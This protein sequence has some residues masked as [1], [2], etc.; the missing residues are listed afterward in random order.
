MVGDTCVEHVR[1]LIQASQAYFEDSFDSTLG[2]V[3]RPEFESALR[4]HHRGD[5][6]EDSVSWFA[7][8]KTVYAAGCRIYLSRNTSMS[9]TEIQT[10]AWGYFQ[11]AMSVLIELLFT[12]TGLLAIRALVAM[13]WNYRVFASVPTDPIRQTFF[14]EGLGNPALEYMLCANA[15]RLAQAKGLHRRP[16]KAWN[17]STHDELHHTWLFW[18]IYCCEKHIAYRSGRPSVSQKPCLGCRLC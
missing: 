16:A 9:F 1:E 8:R 5:T 10:E 17:L 3:Y 6:S 18:A 7:L 4:A 11:S 15:T 12:P 13:V 14:S 2:I